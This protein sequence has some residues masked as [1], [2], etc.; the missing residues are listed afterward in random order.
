MATGKVR[1][2]QVTE[3]SQSDRSKIP[4]ESKTKGPPVDLPSAVANFRVDIKL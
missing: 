4:Q 3:P 2:M 1:G